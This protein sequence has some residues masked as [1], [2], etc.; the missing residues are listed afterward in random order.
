MLA[1]ENRKPFPHGS[2]RLDLARA[3]TAPDNP[4]TARVIVNRVWMHHF[5]EPLVDTPSDFG[6]RST[7][8]R[9]RSCSTTWPRLSSHDGW[10]LKKLHRRIVLSRAYQQAS[11]DRPDVPAPSIRRTGCSGG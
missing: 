6:L 10:S 3:I 2:G 5:G 4:L 7:R 1:G 8:R 11:V 9:T